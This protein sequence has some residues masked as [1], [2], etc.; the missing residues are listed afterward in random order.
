MKTK[1]KI[2]TFPYLFSIFAFTPNHSFILSELLSEC[3]HIKSENNCSMRKSLEIIKSLRENELR[4]KRDAVESLPAFKER[5]RM[6]LSIDFI[7][8]ELRIISRF[9]D[10]SFFDV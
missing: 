1:I 3:K 2:G 9:S 6:R 7:E 8:E 4:E 10:S 5:M